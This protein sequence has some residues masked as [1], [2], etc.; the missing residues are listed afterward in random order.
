MFHV[1]ELSLYIC[2]YI[3]INQFIKILQK[4]FL[5]DTNMV[6]SLFMCIVTICV[7]D[8]FVIVLF[9]QTII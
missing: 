9:V 3:I 8:V 5:I 4:I 2:I 7:S 1:V 6:E